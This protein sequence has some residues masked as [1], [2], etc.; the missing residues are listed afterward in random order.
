MAPPP[1]AVAAPIG[2][3][4]AALDSPRIPHRG[5][6]VPFLPLQNTS[7][8]STVGI[9]HCAGAVWN[10]SSDNNRRHHFGR[11]E[12]PGCERLNPVVSAWSRGWWPGA[13]RRSC[14]YAWL[15]S[16]DTGRWAWVM[17]VPGP[18]ASVAPGCRALPTW[19]S[20][21]DPLRILRAP[22]AVVEIVGVRAFRLVPR[23]AFRGWHRGL[24]LTGLP[25]E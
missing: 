11:G 2:L 1:A 14:L 9:R 3:V 17:C 4:R 24:Y 18:V 16:G 12:R 8:T 19:A 6:C 22:A 10:F 20:L 21:S 7:I 13:G 23:R 15:P 25:R 5:S